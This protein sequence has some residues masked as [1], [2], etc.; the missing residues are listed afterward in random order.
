[1]TV[2]VPP[3]P[4]Q[5]RIVARLDAIEAHRRAAK[6]KLDQLPDLLDRYRQSVLAAAF[7]G[8][9]TA[10]WRE[11]HPDTEP[12][13]TLLERI[14]AERRRRWIE[15]KAQKATDRAQGRDAKKGQTWTDA[16]RAARLAKERGKAAKKYQPAPPADAQALGDLPTG[17]VWTTIDEEDRHPRR[18]PRPDQRPRA[19]RPDRRA[20]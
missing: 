7:R 17:W 12:A 1:M 5:R 14:R 8:D 20:Q 13:S 15:D 11:S 3:L 9:V 10:A 2:P 4:E 6:E 16:D 19:S 18:A